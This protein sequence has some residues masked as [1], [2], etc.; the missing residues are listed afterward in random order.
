MTEHI[1]G[2]ELRECLDDDCATCGHPFNPHVLVA[3]LYTP[4]HGGLIF[5]PEPGCDC[6]A[7]WSIRDNELPYIPDEETV[8]GL[9]A[10]AQN[11][12]KNDGDC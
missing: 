4:E 7:T 5:C 9:R 10:L 11:L 6:E 1:D 2:E 8:A 3:T 12:N